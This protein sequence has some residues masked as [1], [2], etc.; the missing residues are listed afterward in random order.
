MEPDGEMILKNAFSA[1]TL[2]ISER[3]YISLNNI[4]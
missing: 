2:K 4:D 1:L 3:W